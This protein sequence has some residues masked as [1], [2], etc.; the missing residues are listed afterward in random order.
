MEDLKLKSTCKNKPREI[1]RE[2][3]CRA[4]LITLMA[5]IYT[6]SV[7]HGS[8]RVDG[9]SITRRQV[10]LPALT[11]TGV[12]IQTNSDGALIEATSALVRQRVEIPSATSPIKTTTI[13]TYTGTA[14]KAVT[15]FDPSTFRDPNPSGNTDS[16]SIMTNPNN[17][18]GMS[19]TNASPAATYTYPV[20]AGTLPA[21]NPLGG[22][23]WLGN[24]G[25][26]QGAVGINRTAAIGTG[27]GI[28]AF[29]CPLT[30]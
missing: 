25:A 3:M 6:T 28:L 23:F 29:I 21:Q 20:E 9:Q 4:K 13:D 2:K 24:S 10:E 19:R 27:S 1:L 11:V 30:P 18:G 8:T 7:A 17:C 22:G 15:L 26:D 5:L 14:I 16:Q 12:S